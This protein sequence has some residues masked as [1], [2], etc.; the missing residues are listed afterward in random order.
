VKDGAV[1][2]EAVAPIQLPLEDIRIDAPHGRVSGKP[3]SGGVEGR[4]REVE[5]GDF[6]ITARN[7]LVRKNAP[8]PPTSITAL[9]RA[10]PSVSTSSSDTAADGYQLT[11]STPREEYASSQCSARE[12]AAL[13]R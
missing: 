2:P 7:E 8:P 10:T 9:S 1:V 11:P 3:S 4:A 13:T 6:R 5:H 12:L